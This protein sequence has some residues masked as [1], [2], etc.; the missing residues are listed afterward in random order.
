LNKSTELNKEFE[1]IFDQLEEQRRKVLSLVAGIDNAWLTVPPKRGKW[2]I[3][4]ILAHV[5]TA[6]ELSIRYMQKKVLGI[7]E[8]KNSG[9]IEAMKLVV[10][11]MMQRVPLK[12][13]A[14][15]V[16]VANTP[17][18]ITF[19][20]LAAR[21]D[22]NRRNLR[23]LLNSIPESKS[24]RLIYKHVIVGRLNASQAMYFF[25][26]HINHHLPQIAAILKRK[27]SSRGITLEADAS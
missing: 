19:S 26:E 17:Q 5:M 15:K 11:N 27:L 9:P 3:I 2:S 16:V 21:W 4:Q 6:E 20:E 25:R 8:V 10:L 7:D 23:T 22:E 13:N 14:P 24:K 12:Y 1:Q 18:Q